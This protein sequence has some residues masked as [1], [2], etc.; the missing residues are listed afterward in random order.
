M[1]FVKISPPTGP[2]NVSYSISTPESHN[3][4]TILHGLPTVLFL[5]PVYMPQQVFEAQFSDLGLR[6]FNLI[7]FDMRSHGETEGV[8]GDVPYNAA[9]DV[10]HFIQALEL[11][12]CHV[13]AL[14]IGC[15]VALELASAHPECLLSLMLCSPLSAE[16]PEDIVAGRLEIHQYWSQASLHPGTALQ[17]MLTRG[18]KSVAYDK[19]LLDEAV[20]GMKQLAFNNSMNP[21]TSAIVN[22]AISQSLHHWAGTEERTKEGFQAAVMWPLERKVPS[23]EDFQKIKCPIRIIYC[24][25]DVAY[26]SE[27]AQYLQGQLG[28]AGLDVRLHQVHGPHYG[29]VGGAKE[30]VSFHL[31]FCRSQR[32][33][34][35]YRW[36][37]RINPILR[38][39]VL[40]LHVNQPKVM[41][42]SITAESDGVRMKTPFDDLLERFDYHPSDQPENE[43]GL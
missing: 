29:C 30:S 39:F 12:P 33:D 1:P 8:I 10:Y 3:A 19:Q 18:E 37:D 41:N 22:S 40:S 24:L 38:Q 7:A 25:E 34:T 32:A 23:K 14:S 11:P 5:H 28:D 20:L 17:H 13:F 26:T 2:L 36:M 21:L 16:E 43:L 6:Q 35:A 9:E 4:E 15:S 42:V 27:S 31:T